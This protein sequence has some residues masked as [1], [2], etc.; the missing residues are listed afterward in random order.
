LTSRELVRPSLTTSQRSAAQKPARLWSTSGEVAVTCH[1]PTGA[2]D[3]TVPDFPIAMVT[4]VALASGFTFRRF[5]CPLTG[6]NPGQGP[7]IASRR[8]TARPVLIGP[9]E[10][11]DDWTEPQLAR[12]TDTTAAP[13][14]EANLPRTSASSGNNEP[15]R[16]HPGFLGNHAVS[17]EDVDRLRR[18]PCRRAWGSETLDDVRSRHVTEP[19]EGTWSLPREGTGV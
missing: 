15:N 5:T 14:A 8:T 12:S 3:V 11:P 9:Y 6:T 18:S 7:P 16:V 2:W 13:S 1:V 4:S 19:P 17:I 10:G